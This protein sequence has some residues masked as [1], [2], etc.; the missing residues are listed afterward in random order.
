MIAFAFLQSLGLFIVDVKQ[1]TETTSGTTTPAPISTTS[2]ETTTPA[3][4]PI[5]AAEALMLALENRVIVDD[6]GKEGDYCRVTENCGPVYKCS[7]NVVHR[8]V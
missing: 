4:V 7:A 1:N 2:S 3:P 8:Y 6:D 5:S